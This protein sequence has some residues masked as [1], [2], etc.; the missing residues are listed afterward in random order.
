MFSKYLGDQTLASMLEGAGLD[1]GSP[2]LFY[3]IT[4]DSKKKRLYL[5]LVNASSTPQPMVI[6]IPGL[7]LAETGTLISLTAQSTQATNTIDQPNQIVPIE[8][9]LHGVGDHLRH[10]LPG[11]AIQ[12]LQLDEQ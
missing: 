8:T 5:K 12:V 11:Y 1:S 6:D 2:K 10:T 4:R 9:P 7:K 3:S